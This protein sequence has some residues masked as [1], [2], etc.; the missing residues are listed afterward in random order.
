[1]LL[2]ASAGGTICQMTESQVK[3]LIEKICM[4]EYCSKSERLVKLEIVGI[5]KVMIPLDT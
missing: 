2:D 5:P 4:N 3:G 1:M